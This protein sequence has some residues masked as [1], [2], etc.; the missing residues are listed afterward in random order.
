MPANFGAEQMLNMA[1][2]ELAKALV[3][4]NTVEFLPMSL[5]AAEDELNRA[6]YH[7]GQ[8][9]YWTTAVTILGIGIISIGGIA[10]YCYC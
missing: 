9:S 10:L 6:K 1:L 8:Y 5:T 2:I 7:L 4:P 3:K